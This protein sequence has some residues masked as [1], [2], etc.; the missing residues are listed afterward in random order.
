LSALAGVFA[1]LASIIRQSGIWRFFARPERLSRLFHKSAAGRALA[2][3]A[4]GYTRALKR[5]GA[6]L[7]RAAP[8]SFTLWTVKWLGERFYLF[9]CLFVAIHTLTPFEMYRNPYTLAALLFLAASYSLRVAFDGARS[10]SAKRHDPALTLYFA[11]M[12]VSAALSLFGA[13]AGAGSSTTSV[14][15]LAAILFAFLVADAFSEPKSLMALIYAIAASALAMSFYG[16]WQYARGVPID[17]TLTDR[18]T[19]GASLAMGRVSA[20]L[21][22][23][24][25]LA[26]WLILVIPFCV[27]LIF[28]SKGFLAKFMLALAAVPPIACLLLTQSRSGWIGMLVAA[29]VFVFLLDWRLLPV[30]AALAVLALPFLP[31]FI[32]DRLATLGQDTSSVSRY[33]IYAGAFR[34]AL[35]NWATGIGIGMEYF[36]RF[37]NN[38]VYFPYETAPNHSHMLPLQIWLESGIIAAVAF[39][40]SAARVMKKCFSRI[41]AQK[42]DTLPLYNR[43][44]NARYGSRLILTACM[45]SMLGFLAMSCFEYVWFYPRC[46]NQFFII[47]GVC[48]CAVG[49]AQ[50]HGAKAGKAWRAEAGKA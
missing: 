31:G 8:R 28:I 40:W 48:A 10:F 30:F 11:A 16:I 35:S 37:I 43:P 9:F 42:R 13:G 33:T 7:E 20:T 6:F 45:S 46:M 29:I 12:A 1:A 17:S 4:G 22:N 24:N 18:N 2:R 21:G 25:V 27:A 3:A 26:G 39:F 41:L 49:Q 23:P 34:M 47:A 50:R 44:G 19:G 38:Y 36:K 15:Y 5:F 14:L 32:T